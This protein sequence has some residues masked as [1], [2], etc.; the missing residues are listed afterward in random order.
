MDNLL[1]KC[2]LVFQMEIH[3]D[4]CKFSSLILLGSDPIRKLKSEPKIYDY[5]LMFE[6]N[7]EI[8]SSPNAIIV[9]R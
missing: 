8:R 1:V 9:T 5:C 4:S 7:F 6:A 3:T 2:E